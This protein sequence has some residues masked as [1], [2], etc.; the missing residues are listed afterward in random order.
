MVDKTEG[1]IMNGQSREIGNIGHT[2][3]TKRQNPGLN[4][5][6]RERWLVPVCYKTLP[7]YSYNKYVFDATMS[8]QT[9]IT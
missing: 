8:K 2:R 4:P 3:H 9:Q 7:C 5:C 1:V 6:V